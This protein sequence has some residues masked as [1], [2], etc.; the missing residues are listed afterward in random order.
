VGDTARTPATDAELV[1]DA[2]SGSRA[3]FDALV[4][5]YQGQAVAVAQSV[6]RNFELAKDAAQNAFV[7]A[8]LG[9]GSFREDAKFKTWFIRIVFNEAKTV[10]RKERARGAHVNVNTQAGDADEAQSIYEVIPSQARGPDE[11]AQGQEIRRCV[12]RAA[13]ALPERQQEVFVLRYL[14]G[15]QLGEVADI[16][17]ISVGTVKAHLSQAGDKVR[18]RL[19]K[20]G[21]YHG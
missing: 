16:L 17:E 11:E 7:K 1:T 6:L 13:R 8:Y 19:R 5:R 14:E 4:L 10:W 2:R 12:E 9:L 20:E 15:F 3:A 21:T 18:Q